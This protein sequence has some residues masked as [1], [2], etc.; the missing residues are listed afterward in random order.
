MYT[1]IWELLVDIYVFLYQDIFL[2]IDIVP[3]LSKWFQVK[4]PPAF[5]SGRIWEYCNHTAKPWSFL[6]L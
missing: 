4:N 2:G 6:A 1:S 5:L 3:G